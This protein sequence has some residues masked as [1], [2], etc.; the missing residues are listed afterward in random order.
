MLSGFNMKVV[1]YACLSPIEFFPE[2]RKKKR[3]YSIC[4]ELP[5]SIKQEHVYEKGTALAIF[6]ADKYRPAANPT[7]KFIIHSLRN[8]SDLKL[9]VR[10]DSS[11]IKATIVKEG[12]KKYKISGCTIASKGDRMVG[13][14]AHMMWAEAFEF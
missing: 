9:E 12:N 7:F 10:Y 11:V 2:P 3:Y 1:A 6:D 8:R 13:R 5:D 14:F 4:A